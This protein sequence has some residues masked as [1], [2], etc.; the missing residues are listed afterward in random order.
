MHV[1]LRRGRY[2]WLAFSIAFMAVVGALVLRHFHFGAALDV[3]AFV[4]PAVAPRGC[5]RPAPTAGIDAGPWFVVRAPSNYDP[6]FAHPLL[7]VFSPA[8]LPAAL[9]E[10]HLGL[11]RAATAAGL[12]VA[13]V[14][15]L[16]LSIAVVD[17]F[18]QVTARVARDWCI[19]RTRITL[20]GHSDG[21]TVAQLLAL[22]DG[23]EDRPAAI[24]ASAAGLRA[25]DF[26]AFQCPRSLHVR[27]W[28]G[29]GDRHFAGYGASA[30]A[31][32][33]RCLACSDD[34]GTADADGCFTYAGCRGSLR[35]C[36]HDGGHLGWPSAATDALVALAASARRE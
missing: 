30:A 33:A 21:G 8:G 16:P 14:D 25:E 13:Y 34:R 12:I 6:D 20:S 27:L 35:Y 3:A 18:A 28:H 17:S 9:A 5:D 29:S 2:G 31:A 23:T 24:V 22:R 32:W 15:S 36:A 7:V 1:P 26:V 4:Y 11:T 19:D 10:R